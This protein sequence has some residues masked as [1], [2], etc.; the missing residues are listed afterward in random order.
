MKP[1]KKLT[2]D[3]I[4]LIICINFSLT[5]FYKHSPIYLS[6]FVHRLFIVFVVD[7]RR[8]Q[9]YFHFDCYIYG[10]ASF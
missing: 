3:A 4:I 1:F 6:L 9:L 5:L 2:S 8:I 10:M 7:L